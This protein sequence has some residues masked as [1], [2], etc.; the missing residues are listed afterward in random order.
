LKTFKD[1]EVWQ[2]GIIL[3]TEIYSITDAFP[4]TEIY[5]LTSQIRRAVVSVPS[6]IAEGYRRGHKKQF[7]QFLDIALGSLG[8]VETQIIIS[9]K[10]GYVK[11]E[12]LI[13]VFNLINALTG[14]L[15]S[16][17]NKIGDEE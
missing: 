5:A 17:I 9:E 2:K 8:E 3:V 16:F 4:K 1:L 6:N 14:M 10:L 7:K 12:R 15:I 13:D 11:N